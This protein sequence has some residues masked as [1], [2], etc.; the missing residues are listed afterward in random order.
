MPNGD[1][2]RIS[3][4]DYLEQ[5][6]AWINRMVNR[7]AISA[8]T[9]EFYNEHTMRIIRAGIPSQMSIEDILAEEPPETTTVRGGI[10]GA[11]EIPVTPF[12]LQDFNIETGNLPF[13]PQ[14]MYHPMATKG[15]LHLARVYAVSYTHL[16][17]PTIYSV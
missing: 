3:V 12:T 10:M 15:A 16:T 7:G 11:V 14:V 13:Y 4:K 6:V 1:D 9:A 17:L 8:E 2:F 5:Y